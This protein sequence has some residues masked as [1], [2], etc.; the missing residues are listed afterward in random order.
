MPSSEKIVD[1]H[2]FIDGI[3]TSIAS[4]L[5]PNT[6]ARYIL[7]CNILSQGAGSV[8]IITNVKGNTIISFDLPDGENKCI[9]T[10]NDEENNKF[11]YLLWNSNSLHG[12]YIFDG[13][14]KKITRY[15]LNLTDTG[16]VDIMGL[17]PDFLVLHFDI[18]D[19]IAYW[20]D[21][22]NNARKTNLD[23]LLDKS[24]TGYGDVILQSFIDAYK[25]TA[26]FAPT[27]VYFTD[28]TKVINRMYG[29]IRK[30]AQLYIYDDKERSVYSDWSAVVLPDKEPFTGINTIPVNNNGI[31][32][33]VE[34][35]SRIVEYIEII[36]Q[37]TS[38][39][40]N[41][42]SILNWVLIATLDKKKLNIPDNSTYVYNFFNDSNYPVVVP[43]KVIQPYSFMQE[44]PIGQA[45][46]KNSMTYAGGYEG[47]PVVDIDV[48]VSVT[49]EDLFLEDSVDN[50]FNEPVYTYLSAPG[51]DADFVTANQLVTDVNGIPSLIQFNQSPVRFTRITLTI[52]NDV[53]EGNTF[54]LGLSN[55]HYPDNFTIQYTALNTDSAITVANNIT[56]LLVNTGRIYRKTPDLPE[57]N[58]Y[59]H[60][61]DGGGNVTFSFIFRA[62]RDR[63]YMTGYTSVNPVQFDSLKDTGQ[64][65]RN[66]KMGS[67]I[68]LGIEY[69]DFDGRKSLVY[70]VD[71]LIVGVDTINE[72]GGM[73]KTKIRVQINHKAPNW[74]KYY[75][76][77]RTNDLRYSDFIQMLIQQ[78]VEVPSTTTS[79]YLDL[80]I[81]SLYTYQKIHPNTSLTYQFEKGD[82]LHLLQKTSDDSYYPYF[83][84][85]IIDYKD[86][87]TERITSNLTTNGSSTI[88]VESASADNIGRFIRVDGGEREIIG[89]PSG[90]TYMLNANIGDA[91]A[92]TYLYYD[93]IDYR[94]IIRIKKP[95][96][97]IISDFEDLSMVEVYKQSTT[98]DTDKKF[99]EFQKKFPIVNAGTDEAYHSANVQIQTASLP[100]IV[101]ISEGTVYVRNREM[102]INNI[103][104]G[105]Q[106]DIRVIEDPS[107]SD[108]YPSLFNDNGR[109][110]AEDTGQGV[111]HVEDRIRFSSVRLE[112][113]GING[114]NDFENLNREDYNDKYGGIRLI[115]FDT[116]R[117]YV[118]KE[119]KTGYV[120]VDAVLTQDNAGQS[121]LITSSKFLNPMQYFAW[122]GGI[123]DNPESYASN[124]TSKYWLSPNSG[125][126]IR[127]GGNGEEPISKTYYLDNEVR[128]LITGAVNNN[129][130][131]FGGFDRVNGVYIVSIEGYE[132]YI[133]FDGF[134]G[135]TV[136]QPILPSDTLFEI[137][138]SPTNGTVDFTNPSQWTYTPDTDFIGHDEFT[139]RAFVD[140]V[141][142]QPEEVCIDIIEQPNRLT[143]WRQQEPGSCVLD[144]YGLQTGY[145]GW[146]TLEQ[147]YLDDNS[148]TGEEKPNVISDANYVA[149][150][151]DATTCV[152]VIPDPNPNPFTFTD[153]TGAEPSTLYTSNSVTITGINIP[154]PI[155]VTAGKEYSIDGG[156]WV[157]ASGTITNGQTVRVRQTT[158]SLYNTAN[159]ATLTVGSVSDTYTV[160]T[161]VGDP[162]DVNYDI[163]YGVD[164]FVELGLVFN[165]NGIE[166]ARIIAE[167]SGSI[168]GVFFEGDT[169]DVRQVTFPTVF[170]WTPSSNAN[171]TID[172]NTVEVYNDNRTIQVT[173]LQNYTIVIPTGTTVYDVTCTGSS[174]AMGY[175]TYALF[176]NNGLAQNRLRV[177][178]DDNTTTDFV[179]NVQP[180]TGG[181]STFNF[182][183]LDN[184]DLMTVTIYNQSVYDVSCEVTGTGGY[185]DSS[186]ILA[187]GNNVLSNVPKGNV[188]VTTIPVFSCGESTPYTGG[189]AFPTEIV[190]NLGSAMG[191]VNFDF[192]AQSIPDKFIV[193]FDSIEVINTGY[194]GNTTEQA[195]LDA[196]LAARGLP[197]ETITA[198]GNGTTS[199]FKGTATTT[200][201]VKVYGP[202]AGTSWS[203][204]MECPVP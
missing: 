73:K 90:T 116:N 96:T 164:P 72:Q 200:A 53:K 13:L 27:G 144:E 19:N 120:P 174:T 30:F 16:N 183:V 59:T 134:N 86:T 123:G 151:Y 29:A 161:R 44:R 203:F 178:I 42:E 48:S 76:I 195:N 126:I 125:V 32:I 179:I 95:S 172:R 166:V 63:N 155:S 54:T 55:G 20:V 80:V 160:T 187:G 190:I 74:A 167:T 147:F 197:P 201:L 105:T 148:V 58:I 56:T 11:G 88:T 21:G 6:S 106:V 196:A 24:D 83:E 184:A 137:V 162:V 25:H 185:S 77:V 110:N 35:G 33:T 43:S 146:T 8:G 52:G 182:N 49:Y 10:A 135:W 152:P 180:A 38:A 170:P 129:A 194:R 47:K 118:W 199:F 192:D 109:A 149:P 124:G 57:S 31:Q 65:I 157:T 89:A 131:I 1:S 117:L 34:T 68:K 156:A 127:L 2:N 3:N 122:E 108:F 14:T 23:K 114:F 9:G 12:L 121:L 61:V 39:E 97:D 107:Y 41:D 7:N 171:L 79:E 26:A 145:Y 139:Y 136:S 128:E 111:V 64:S 87:V 168:T 67:T 91:T 36:M 175:K 163:V 100:A 94:G 37:S 71:A 189:E 132:S 153:I 119:L 104:P 5:L 142:S 176:T 202:L 159:N 154:A 4:E 17:D 84:T 150:I 138:D 66:I 98:Q 141:W 101:E 75:Q 82:I 99:F 140:G 173:E 78:V 103:Y 81:G 165:R 51:T 46:A 92:K 177:N 50:E 130:K 22:K 158:S 15:L 45:I 28:T 60:S 18:V 113:T 40:P 191:T 93:L 181:P 115:K 186:V 69:E 133:Y 102:P 188:E 204:T 85:E 143:G 169:I 70:T 193:E 62:S 198:P 112:G